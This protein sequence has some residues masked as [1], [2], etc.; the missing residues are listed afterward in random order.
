MIR[1]IPKVIERTALTPY[2]ILFAII[3]QV[4]W[5]GSYSLA[6]CPKPVGPEMGKNGLG[7]QRGALVFTKD[8]QK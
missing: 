8:H 4:C 3:K 7:D 2:D 1:H 5:A 6:F